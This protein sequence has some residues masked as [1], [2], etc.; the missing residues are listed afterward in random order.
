ME[1]ENSNLRAEQ[2]LFETR[3][4]LKKVCVGLHKSLNPLVDKP[5]FTEVRGKLDTILLGLNQPKS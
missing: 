5:K 2:I 3:T 1:K 4:D